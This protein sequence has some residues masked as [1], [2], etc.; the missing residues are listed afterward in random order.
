VDTQTFYTPPNALRLEWKSMPNG[1]WVAQ[2]NV[3]KFRNREINFDGDTFYSWCFSHEAIPAPV[4]PLIQA[5]DTD[6]NF[7]VPLALGEFVSGVPPE[8]WIQVKIPLDA[9][10]SASIH[11]FDPHRIRAVHFGQGVA[12]ATLRRLLIDEMKIDDAVTAAPTSASLATASNDQTSLPPPGDVRAVGYERHID[13]AW[14]PVA[15]DE[16]QSYVIYRSFD[17]RRFQPVGI[18]ERGVA[19]YCDFLGQQGQKA[20]YKVT[21]C[22]RRYRQSGFSSEVSASTRPLTDAELLTMLQEACFRYYW[23]RP[24]PTAGAALENIPG[25]D[26]IVTTGATGFGIM[27]LIVGINRGFVTRQQGADRLMKIVNFLENA[28]RH[29]GAWSHF[30]DGETGKTLPIFGTFD[31]G[32]DLVE[33]AFLMEGLLAARQ[34]FRGS[35]DLERAL[36]QKITHLWE[37]IEWD[38]YRGSS[39]TDALYW[40]WSSDWAWYISHRLTGW[41][42]V[43]IVYLLA[44]ASPTHGVPASLYYSGWA[45]QSQAAI[46]YRR[47]W[48][49]TTVGDRYTNGNTYYGIKLDVGVDTGGPLFFTQYSFM[50]FD[51]RG[52]HDR[53]T[54][55]FRNNR[56]IALI[57]LAYCI[58]N[59]GH[60]KGYGADCWGLTASDDPWDYASHEPTVRRQPGLCNYKLDDG[61]IAPTGALA[62]FPYTPKASLTALK[63]FYRD[64]GDRLWGIYGP[65]DAFNLTI[66]WFAPIYMGL[67]QAPITVMIENYRTGLVW[68]L[69]MSNPEIR[70]ML[71][72]VGFKSEDSSPRTTHP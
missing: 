42:E 72:R 13:I 46:K 37:T 9:F 20:Y 52:I 59:P 60:Y 5:V 45:S 16:L 24:H 64:L 69:F 7:S 31:N 62:S 34:Y 38:W 57:N 28:R 67:D 29:H 8:K 36:Y 63:H 27:A 48:S 22:D 15:S 1:G 58:R 19:R 17:A 70:A 55:Y 21:A 2:L 25:D 32:G 71:D 68:K 47:A 33:T 11:R 12:D 61:T 23:E 40:H 51:P 3:I 41:N 30:M 53:Y 43:M 14:E 66:D 54:E 65:R 4:L 10:A 49:G 56:A 26:R 44:I 50:G 6:G 39:E 35:S 18:Q